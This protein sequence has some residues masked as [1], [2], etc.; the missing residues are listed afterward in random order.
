MLP[1]VVGDHLAA[2]AVLWN[3]FLLVGFSL[4]PF[5][6]GLGWIYLLGAA[7]GGGYFIYRNIQM[8]REPTR[9][10]AMSSFFASL[11]QLVVLLALAV[12][13]VLLIV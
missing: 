7:S 1:V 10:T 8:V 13:D 3:T 2:K 9:K 12:V 11:I 6:Y 5:F 4:L